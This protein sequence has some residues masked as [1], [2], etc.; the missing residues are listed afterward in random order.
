[1]PITPSLFI[2]DKH[3]SACKTESTVHHA[4]SITD[5][6]VIGKIK[7]GI[8]HRLVV[9]IST[10]LS[11]AKPIAQHDTVNSYDEANTLC[12][13]FCLPYVTYVNVDV[14]SSHSLDKHHSVAVRSIED[15]GALIAVINNVVQ[16]CNCLARQTL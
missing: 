15:P 14:C 8:F 5:K 16:R 1:M 3:G 11:C 12:E 7:W 2:L 4:N 13:K 10:N 9:K 6:P